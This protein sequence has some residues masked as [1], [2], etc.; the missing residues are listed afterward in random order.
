MVTMDRTHC[1]V[2][3]LITQDLLTNVCKKGME[4]EASRGNRTGLLTHS[5]YGVRYF[6]SACLISAVCSAS[7]SPMR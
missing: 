5:L 7:W 4:C 2:Q 6:P 3:R 1:Q